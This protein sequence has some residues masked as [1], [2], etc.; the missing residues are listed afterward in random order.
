MRTEK[1]NAAEREAA[2]K[3]RERI[4]RDFTTEELKRFG[5]ELADNHRKAAEV[6]GERKAAAAQF[7][8]RMDTLC[9][10]SDELANK[11]SAG[12]EFVKEET[13]VLYRPK[14]REKD[15]F[16]LETGEFIETAPMDNA[17]FQ[18]QLKIEKGT[19]AA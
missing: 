17:D 4:R 16:E 5:K 13:L 15:I 3:S 18:A 6:E 1:L 2:T 9:A 11:L 12:F 10:E 7:K 14:D 19:E 8:S